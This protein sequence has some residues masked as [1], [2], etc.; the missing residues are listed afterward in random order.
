MLIAMD[1]LVVVAALLSLSVALGKRWAVW[2]K[3]GGSGGDSDWLALLGFLLRHRPIR[4]KNW[5]RLFHLFLV[6]GFAFFLVIVFLDQVDGH[7]FG[8]HPGVVSLLLDLAGSLMLASTLFFILKRLRHQHYHES[9]KTSRRVVLPLCLLLL[10]LLS[11]FL[12][13]GFRLAITTG[14]PV[15]KAPVGYMLSMVLPGSPL[16]MQLSIRL[17]FYLVLI[18]FVV[19]P[20]TFM[21]H[22]ASSGLGILNRQP[23]GSIRL[24]RLPVPGSPIAADWQEPPGVSHLLGVEACVACGNCVDNCPASI[25]GK[26]LLPGNMMQDLLRRIEQSGLQSPTLEDLE[27]AVSPEI[28]WS[29][30]QCMACVTHCPVSSRPMDLIS[31]MRRRLVLGRGELP[32][33][34]RPMIRNLE[35]F[36]DAM[37]KGAAHRTD[38][39]MGESLPAVRSEETDEP[40]LLWVGC[41]GAFHP[42]NAE[43]MRALV[44]ILKAAEVPFDILGNEELCCGEPARRLGGET[45]FRELA[46]KNSERLK[47][48]GIR[49]ILTACPH[50]YQTLKKEYPDLGGDFQVQHATELIQDLIDDQRIELTYP[51]SG[52]AISIHDP[53]YL[54]RGSGVYDPLRKIGKAIPG[55]KLV[56][57]P[58]NK[59][60]GFCCGGGGGRM[61]LHEN[62]G[63]NINLMRAEEVQA[64]GAD[65]VATACPF[66][67]VM[68]EDGI[69][70]LEAEKKPRVA[71]LIDLVANA[72]K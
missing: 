47:K 8:I 57:M 45:L 4:Y 43:T 5:T 63:R 42:R 31:L 50:C 70:G 44:K 30:T 7:L 6:W 36:G 55:G 27:A 39:L 3:A 1:S 18:F 22:V 69:S 35:M 19:M 11:G 59:E 64:T 52:Q 72:M 26:P 29:C 16:A 51:F 49:N 40:W 54:G 33:E 10:I 14:D 9:G 53:C 61:W 17:H 67:L 58:R 13:E 32:N 68:M 28:L 60:N 23:A 15:W 46:G 24:P 66:C 12:A 37:G 34:A 56:E 25:S 62:Q 65:V 2:R 48:R 41:S 71:D 20:Y 38:W 21:R